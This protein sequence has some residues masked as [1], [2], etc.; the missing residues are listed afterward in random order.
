MGSGGKKSDSDGFRIT[1]TCVPSNKD[2]LLK[3]K[4]KII[5]Q[6]WM[7]DHTWTP[8]LSRDIFFLHL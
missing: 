1:N 2:G 4:K 6:V 3:K 7:N 8:L 5:L